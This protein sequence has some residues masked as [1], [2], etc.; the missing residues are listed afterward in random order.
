MTH[1]KT[2]EGKLVNA[3]MLSNSATVQQLIQQN[4]AYKF[5]KQV[6]G[7]PAYW[8][9]QLYDTLAMMKALGT[10]T[11]FTTLSPAEFLWPEIIQAIGIHYGENFTDEDVLNMDWSTKANYLQTN[12]VKIVSMYQYRVQSFFS[13]WDNESC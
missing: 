3:G 4:H 10:P 12:P 6:R 11:W 1:G 13:K 2:F 5:M 9:H 8:Q 7:T